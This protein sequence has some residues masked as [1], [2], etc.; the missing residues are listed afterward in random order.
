MEKAISQKRIGIF[1]LAY[2][3]WRVFSFYLQP[4]TPLHDAAIINSVVGVIYAAVAAFLLIRKNPWGWYLV[5]LEIILGGTESFVGIYHTSLRTVLLILSISIF[6]LQ[7]IWHKELSKLLNKEKKVVII[8]ILLLGIVGFSALCGLLN[9][10]D[11]HL[12]SAELVSYLFLLYYFPLR[13]L[14]PDP[15]FRSVAASALVAAIIGNVLV[16]A[17]TFIGFATGW[18]VLQDTYYHWFRD[19]AAGKITELPFHFYRLVLNEHLVLVPLTLVLVWHYLG[20]SKKSSRALYFVLLPMMLLLLAI[21][22]TRIYYLAL[23]IGY[24]FLFTKSNWRRWL[25]TGIEGVIIFSV[26]FTAVH[27]AASRGQSLGWEIFGLRLQSIASPQIEDSSL[28]RLIL[29]PK[30]LEKIAAHPLLGSGLGD[31]VSAYSP[32]F[33]QTIT[34]SN[35]DW[36]YLQI[37]E[38]LGLLGLIIWIALLYLLLQAYK[39]N[40]LTKADVASIIA[41]LVINLTS[42]AL[43]HVMGVIWLTTLLA[44]ANTTASLPALASSDL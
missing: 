14:L 24:L 43:F 41:L 27:L 15:E 3:I 19:V 38:E 35:F 33:K 21:S 23:I 9:H 22:L 4:A 2:L 28:S 17:Y 30:I 31:T 12:I 18:H 34:T 39:K 11:P 37:T 44:K 13:E 10:H 8:Y 29:L 1:L 7:K 5:A 26:L 36:G 32:V 16:I 40:Q 20:R 25:K 6:F 42:P